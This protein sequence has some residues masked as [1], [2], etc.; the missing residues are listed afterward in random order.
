[1]GLWPRSHAD[2]DKVFLSFF[3][4]LF[5]SPTLTQHRFPARTTP[6]TLGLEPGNI[7]PR[8]ICAL[9]ESPIS[10]HS[11]RENDWLTV[12]SLC[13]PLYCSFVANLL[14]IAREDNREPTNA[15]RKK[16]EWDT[17]PVYLRKLNELIG[18]NHSS[19]RNSLYNF[20][21]Q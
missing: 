18:K 6:F 5:L 14:Q 9:I 15:T 13:F 8:D 17:V 2:S 21:Y 20:S 16:L 7:C 4:F 11:L 19:R 3:L 1:M 12:H 10:S